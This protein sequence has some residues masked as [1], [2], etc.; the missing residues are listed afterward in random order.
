VK[1][2]NLRRGLNS[3]SAAIII[4]IIIITT[5]I[6]NSGFQLHFPFEKINQDL[7]PSDVFEM[8]LFLYFQVQISGSML[9]FEPSD[10]FCS[11]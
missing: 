11:R 1:P 2:E 4:L 10:D 7:T 8:M 5:I 9:P 6:T 3:L